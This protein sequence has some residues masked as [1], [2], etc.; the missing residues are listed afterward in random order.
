MK[1]KLSIII[2]VYN[3]EPYLEHTLNTAIHQSLKNIE[4]IAINDGSTDRSLDIL[5]RYSCM[6]PRIIVIDQPDLGQANAM[7]R[8]LLTASGEYVAELDSDDWLQLFAYERMYAK[9]EGKADVVRCGWWNV[10][11]SGESR[12]FT[13]LLPY[14]RDRIYDPRTEDLKGV[15]AVMQKQAAI[16]TGIYRRDFLLEHGIKYRE[17]HNFEDTSLEFRIRS[18]ARDY[19]FVNEALYYYRVGR[20]GS[21]SSTI[22]DNEAIIEQY[23]EILRFNDDH[24]LPFHDFQNMMRYFGYTWALKRSGGDPELAVILGKSLKENEAP[25]NMFEFAEDYRRYREWIDNWG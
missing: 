1:P 14:E 15:R 5:L 22:T 10:Y 6:D 3:A 11:E 16:Y 21:G 18:C 8:G 19:R 12:R 24:G 2:P 17:G 4:I 9:G 25:A 13:P 20:P 7:N 23:D